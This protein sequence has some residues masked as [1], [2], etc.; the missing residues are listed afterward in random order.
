MTANPIRLVSIG[1]GGIDGQVY[2]YVHRVA[3]VRRYT[4][5]SPSHRR[6][7]QAL[8]TYAIPPPVPSP[9]QCVFYIR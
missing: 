6:L 8:L 9:N 7:E 1:R 2:A 4:I 3:T 5:T